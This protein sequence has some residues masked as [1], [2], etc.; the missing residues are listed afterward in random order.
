[1]LPP[2]LNCDILADGVTAA[3]NDPMVLTLVQAGSGYFVQASCYTGQ[4]VVC[5]VSG[6]VYVGATYLQ[7]KN[8]GSEPEFY[9]TVAGAGVGL[10]PAPAASTL[11]P[12]VVLAALGIPVDEAESSR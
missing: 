1:M 9:A 8:S 6:T 4:V 3:G 11:I 7:T 12:N 10:V 2:C 5:V